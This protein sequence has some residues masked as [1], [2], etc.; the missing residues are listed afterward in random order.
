G[1]PL[2]GEVG[3]TGV[4]AAFG[5]HH[6]GLTGGPKTGRMVADMISGNLSNNNLSPYSP[7]RFG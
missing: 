5:H 1:L 7:Q 2:I 4:Y 3:A 6:I